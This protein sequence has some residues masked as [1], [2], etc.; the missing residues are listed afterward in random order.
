MDE[1]LTIAVNGQNDIYL[2]NGDI[3]LARGKDAEAQII[4]A[5]VRTRKGELQFD[6][7]RGIP[8]F[9]T[10]FNSASQQY[11]SL[12]E[13]NVMKAITELDF[14][15]TVVSFEHKIDYAARHI[16]YICKVKTRDD[17]EIEVQST[18]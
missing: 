7:T 3:A 17:E 11:V 15:K 2:L 9:E 13:A 18:I 1:K 16:K 12:W 4:S 5:V 10:I 14:V 8:Y 6:T